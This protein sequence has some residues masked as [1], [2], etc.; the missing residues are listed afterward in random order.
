MAA[1]TAGQTVPFA[2][3]T[4]AVRDFPGVDEQKAFWID[5]LVAGTP[6]GI[7]PLAAGWQWNPGYEAR[8]FRLGRRLIMFTGGRLQ[9]APNAA[10]VNFA[11]G[12]QVYFQTAGQIDAAHQGTRVEEAYTFAQNGGD[13]LLPGKAVMN[14][15]RIGVIMNA[16]MAWPAAPAGGSVAN[17]FIS[18]PSMW[19]L[20]A[21]TPG[22][23]ALPV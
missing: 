20:A 8:M 9:Q 17:R 3:P 16:A 1:E 19:W 7:V 5:A 15:N 22:A 11:A 21:N 14:V 2:L 12:A 23:S 13:A 10:A 6:T 4:D 18:I